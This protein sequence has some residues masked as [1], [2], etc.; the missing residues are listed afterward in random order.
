MELWNS[1]VRSIYLVSASHISHFILGIFLDV[2]GKSFLLEASHY[3]WRQV[4]C[5]QPS[6]STSRISTLASVTSHP[7]CRLTVFY[8]ESSDPVIFEKTIAQAMEHRASGVPVSLLFFPFCEIAPA[9]LPTHP[10][11]F[12]LA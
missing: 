4:S 11:P 9:P 1:F 8:G 3:V 5:S 7:F 10:S 12:F 6:P 2:G